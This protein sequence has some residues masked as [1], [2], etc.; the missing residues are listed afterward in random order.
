MLRKNNKNRV[1]RT[2]KSLYKKG[3]NK[4]KVMFSKKIIKDRDGKTHK[5]DD[6][7]EQA[8]GRLH[9]GRGSDGKTE[10]TVFGSRHRFIQRFAR[11]H[12][13]EPDDV[14]PGKSVPDIGRSRRL[15]VIVRDPLGADRP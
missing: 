15:S 11:Q 9:Q 14:G 12:F 1:V 7:L 4:V 13:A 8:G 2:I 6:L 10:I 5:V 3:H